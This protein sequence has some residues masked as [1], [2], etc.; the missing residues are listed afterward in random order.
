[1]VVRLGGVYVLY[2]A[3]AAPV[4]DR[5]VARAIAMMRIACLL[6]KPDV[7][8]SIEN[9]FGDCTR[10]LRGRG[11]ISLGMIAD[12]TAYEQSAALPE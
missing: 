4:V 5:I 3:C 8:A 1:M 6:S 7:N 10:G 2:W 12:A 9:W 11:S